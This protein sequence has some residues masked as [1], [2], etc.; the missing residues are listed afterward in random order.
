MMRDALGVAIAKR[1]V[2]ITPQ[3][4]RALLV[5]EPTKELRDLLASVEIADSARVATWVR[6]SWKFEQA[7]AAGDPIESIILAELQNRPGTAAIATAWR[8]D[9]SGERI[10]VY[11]AVLGEHSGDQDLHWHRVRR[12]LRR[13]ANQ[14]L[15]EPMHVGSDL[16]FESIKVGWDWP[17]Y[18]RDMVANSRL[19]W[20]ASGE[21]VDLAA[22]AAAQPHDG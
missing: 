8:T 12:A 7:H 21:D 3:E 13:M 2:P 16:L 18:Y 14:G 9:Q 20:S 1:L 11:V 19:L 6:E 4:R 22:L 15:V 5:G 17:V 10:R